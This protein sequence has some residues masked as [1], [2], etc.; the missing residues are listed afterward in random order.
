MWQATKSFFDLPIEDKV[1][2]VTADAKVYPFGYDPLGNEVLSKGKDAEKGSVVEMPG[3]LK[4][5]FSLGPKDPRSGFPARQFPSKPVE[6]EAAW[7]NYYDTLVNLARNILEGFAM[8]LE[9]EPGYFEKFID[10][11][12]SALRALNYP[13]ITRGQE[14]LPGQLRASAHTDYG[15]ITILRTDGPGL[16]VSKD[17]DPPVWHDVPFVENAFIINLGDLMRRW[18]NE[19]WVS[20]LHRVVIS[21]ADI[22]RNGFE[23]QSGEGNELLCR[24]RQSIA[25]FHNVNRDAEINVILKDSNE[26]PK[27]P[28]IIAGDFLMQK[29]LASIGQYK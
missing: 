2:Y 27:H 29:H 1:P 18:T 17:L 10:H 14:V 13:A 8:A 19:R 28:P 16:Q 5:M 22:N 3:D 24:R 6:F 26:K 23:G 4:E 25:F 7:T 20:T 11:H 15:T 21:A 12:A 9:L